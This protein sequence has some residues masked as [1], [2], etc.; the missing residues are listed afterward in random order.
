MLQIRVVSVAGQPPAT[1]IVAQF[2]PAGGSIGRNEGN[3][4]VLPDEAK[5]ISRQHALIQ[6]QGQ[7][8]VLLDKG[9]NPTLRNRVPVGAGQVVP[10]EPGDELCIG[11]YVLTVERPAAA[12]F[13]PNSTQVAPAPVAPVPPSAPAAPFALPPASAAPSAPPAAPAAADDPF[14]GLFGAAPAAPAAARDDPLAGW[15]GAPAPAPAPGPVPAIPDDFD[16]FASLA[17]PEP[18]PTPAFDPLASASRRVPPPI[19]FDPP[20][21]SDDLIAPVPEKSASI[22]ELFGLGNT[23]AD[24]LDVLKSVDPAPSP[25]PSAPVDDPLVLFGGPPAPQG[26]G[27]AQ[28]DHTSAEH[29]AFSLPPV[30]RPATPPPPAP[31]PG[32]APAAASVSPE[33]IDDLLASV[34]PLD[35]SKM[36][37]GQFKA[38]PPAPSVPPAASAPAS[39]RPAGPPA[40]PASVDALM[41]AFSE[42]LGAPVNLPDGVTEEFMYRMGG[43]VREAIKGTV[44]LLNARAVTKREV[45]ASATL[46]MER[47]NNPLKFSPDAKTAMLYLV[48]GRLN[49]AFMPPITAMRDAYNDLRSHQF[50]FMAGTKAALEGVLERFEPQRLESRLT[51]KGLVE[52]LIPAARKARLWDLFNELYQEIA[53]EAEDDFHALFGQAFLKAYEEHVEALR[54]DMPEDE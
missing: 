48:S 25:A 26:A 51:D 2:G 33:Q 34:G 9:A 22:D 8:Y 23:P 54:R 4:L 30:A 50:G 36:P 37:T 14:A 21:G 45:K 47:N 20:G 15:G 3:T 6:M 46:I 41:A 49:P 5:T 17:R 27:P 42:G 7:G 52:S 35:A 43:L 18:A 53:R 19:T 31:A 13:D 10:L 28:P 1:P 39:A 44:D 40:Q 11:P 38:M 12:A 29:M 16:P 32:R 24:P